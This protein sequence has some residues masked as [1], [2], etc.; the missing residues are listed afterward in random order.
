MKYMECSICYE[1]I[2]ESTGQ[3][4]LGCKHSFH[5]ECISCWTFRFEH[6]NQPTCPLCRKELGHKEF[7]WN[8]PSEEPEEEIPHI[9]D[10]LTEPTEEQ[11]IMWNAMALFEDNDFWKRLRIKR[12]WRQRR[13]NHLR[14]WRPKETQGL[15]IQLVDA[16]RHNPNLFNYESD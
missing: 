2:N 5:L 14:R 11:E 13:Q 6:F 12:K 3:C 8:I 1:E 16:P 10:P 7:K 4:I 15:Y 9:R